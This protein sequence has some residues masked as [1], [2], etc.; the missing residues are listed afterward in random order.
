MLRGGPGRACPAPT[1]GG[2][3]A[4]GARHASPARSRQKTA[5]AIARWLTMWGSALSPANSPAKSKVPPVPAVI[6]LLFRGVF[7]ASSRLEWI[8]PFR[9]SPCPI[10]GAAPP[11]PTPRPSWFSWP[12]WRWN[13]PW[14]ST[15]YGP[16]R[17]AWQRFWRPSPRFRARC[18][19]S[20]S[21]CRRPASASGCWCSR[22][23]WRPISC[24]ITGITGSFRTPSPAR[25]PVRWPRPCAMT[26]FF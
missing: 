1:A 19:G 25:R 7:L 9:C 13:G 17:S 26:R 14:V 5:I 22:S 21:R 2:W 18:S 23:G 8:S 16:I 4:V 10:P 11:R 24:S 15:P 3:G 6:T 12:C 20:V